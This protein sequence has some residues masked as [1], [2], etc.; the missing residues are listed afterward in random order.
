MSEEADARRN[1]PEI[2]EKVEKVIK[3]RQAA[4]N[5][6]SELLK[7]ASEILHKNA[8]YSGSILYDRQVGSVSITANSLKSDADFMNRMVSEV[9]VGNL[10]AGDLGEK[11]QKMGNDFPL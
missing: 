10:A 8:R 2:R 4:L 6:A 11:I 5:E 3:A 9:Y 7:K 1:D